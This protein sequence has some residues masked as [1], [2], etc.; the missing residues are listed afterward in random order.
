MND[1][2]GHYYES[3]GKAVWEIPNKSKP[4]TFR[5]TTVGDAKKLGLYVSPTTALKVLAKPE[6]ERWK[7]Q[8]IIWASLSLPRK[9]NEPD[10]DFIGR[11]IEDAF[12]Q[13]DDAADLGTQIHQAIEFHFQ[14]KP[15]DP[16]MD[17]YLNPIKKWIADNKV[18]FLQHETRAIDHAIGVAGTFDATITM[19]G[20][21]GKGTLDFKS[22]KTRRGKVVLPYSAEPMQ[23]AAYCA[24]T[25]SNYAFNIYIST[26]EPGRL[27][28]AFYD[29]A[30]LSKEYD[31]FKQV[32]GVYRHLNQFPHNP[33]KS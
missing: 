16:A 9:D 22:R 4:G 6:L 8:Q 29:S 11:I 7:F 10:E 20:K 1:S 28:T 3:S 26:T 14:G 24:A 31:A 13:V 27:E 5:K 25:G 23:A 17:V 21:E 2:G 15:H 18:T 33:I 30:R 12:K 19:P 32:V